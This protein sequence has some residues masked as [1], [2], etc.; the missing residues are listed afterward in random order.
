MKGSRDEWR[1]WSAD[2]VNLARNSYFVSAVDIAFDSALHD[3]E[4]ISMCTLWV[5]CFVNMID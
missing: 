2:S 3:T 1:A 5:V 4:E